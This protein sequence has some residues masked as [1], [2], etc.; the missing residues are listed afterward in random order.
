M[1][2]ALVLNATYEP[3]S[4]VSAR[5]AVVLLVRDKAELIESQ[6]GHWS[7]ERMSIP[8][9]S[10]IRLL[11]YVKVPYRR[12]VPLNRRAVFARDGHAC[13]Y[14]G[15]PAENL[16]HVVPRSRGG[17]HTWENVVAACRPC[18]TRKGDRTPSESGLRLRRRPLAPREHGWLLVGLGRP[19]DPTWRPYLPSMAV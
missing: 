12:R 19:P 4:V 5:R 18:N 2:Q 1:P 7:S 16:D 10:V 15:G 14:C 6:G 8:V 3:L 9:P 11:R 13:Q 17:E